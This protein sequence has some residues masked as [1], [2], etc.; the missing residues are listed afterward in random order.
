MYAAIP[1]E[2]L[3]IATA[4]YN[5]G[6]VYST[7]YI[8][9]CGSRTRHEHYDTWR[10][11][12]SLYA[13]Y[14]RIGNYYSNIVSRDSVLASYVAT[15]TT[16]D[17]CK[18]IEEIL[19]R[20][21][22]TCLSVL[23]THKQYVVT[24]TVVIACVLAAAALILLFVRSSTPKLV[25]DPVAACSL[26]TASEARELLGVTALQSNDTEPEISGDT[27]ISKCGYTDGNRN[28]EQM[29]VAAV[30]VRSGIN[31]N[32]VAEN[33]EDFVRLQPRGSTEI[34]QNLG[35]AAYFNLTNGQL[36]VL[37]GKQWIIVSYGV[38]STPEA[39]TKED[40]IRLATVVMPSGAGEIPN[41]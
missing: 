38:G 35:D 15:K 29:V 28:T 5:K 24:C 18:K 23:R 39:N 32:G 34:V 3:S 14:R 27:A 16:T 10:D 8:C 13:D 20:F 12:R 2:V 26:F 36:S 6:H 31:E 11:N 7:F 40:A 9:T 22:N 30:I 33:K 1:G 41:F 21:I 25:Y 19:M 17:C 37:D 4:W